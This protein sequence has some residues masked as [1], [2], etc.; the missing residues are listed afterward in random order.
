MVIIY[1]KEYI[2]NQKNTEDQRK[3]KDSMIRSVLRLIKNN[4]FYYFIIYFQCL[5]GTDGTMIKTVFVI[6]VL[7]TFPIVED[8]ENGRE[9]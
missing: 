2:F 3:R 5:L 4:I 9:R 7:M 1:P 8:D 6:M